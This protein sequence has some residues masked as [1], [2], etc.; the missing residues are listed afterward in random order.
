MFSFFSSSTPVSGTNNTNS[1]TAPQTSTTPK[2]SVSSCAQ[3]TINHQPKVTELSSPKK[4]LI[5]KVS[6]PTSVTKSV[7]SVGICIL[8]SSGLK[9]LSHFY[10]TPLSEERVDFY[11]SQI[12]HYN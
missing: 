3:K 7:V 6:E 8:I 5:I 11:Y 1:S 12:E 9:I 2:S 10:G 4:T